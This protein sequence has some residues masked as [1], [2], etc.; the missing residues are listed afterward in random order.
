MSILDL[1]D[2]V[3][4]Q[5]YEATPRQTHLVLGGWEIKTEVVEKSE[6]KA[7]VTGLHM[8]ILLELPNYFPTHH[9]VLSLMESLEA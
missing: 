5:P 9:L 7:K 2:M 4:N 3:N 1:G 8:V 6:L